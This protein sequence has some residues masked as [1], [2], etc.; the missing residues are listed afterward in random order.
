MARSKYW[1]QEAIKRPG[2][3]REWLK[4][5]SRAIAGRYKESPFTERGTIRT[6]VLRKL[7]K[8]KKF[9]KNLAGSRW[10]LISKKVN[11]ALTLRKLRG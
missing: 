5:H 1:I 8:D 2:S 4:K 11:L 10:R 6:S 7:A 9:L 3:L